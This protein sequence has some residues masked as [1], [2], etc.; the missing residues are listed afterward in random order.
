MG[1]FL[2]EPLPQVSGIDINMGCPKSFSVKGGM[3][4]ALLEDPGTEQGVVGGFF[5]ELP[6]PT[7]L[8]CVF[9]PRELKAVVGTGRGCR[10]DCTGV[11]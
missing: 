2:L 8:Q 1:S 7:R 5:G 6:A 9:I 11:G 10:K 3:G 4:A